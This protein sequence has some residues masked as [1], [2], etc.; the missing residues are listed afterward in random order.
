MVDVFFFPQPGLEGNTRKAQLGNQ[1]R[2]Q[3]ELGNEGK[4]LPCFTTAGAFWRS[5]GFLRHF[6]KMT[7]GLIDQL[8]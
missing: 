1:F 3:V 4:A 7:Q 5:N 2:S 8:F 6:N